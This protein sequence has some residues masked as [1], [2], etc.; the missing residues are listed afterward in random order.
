MLVLTTLFISISD[1]LPKTSYVKA[2]D[3]WLIINLLVP[4]FE[5]ILQTLI[6]TW[7]EDAVDRAFT[8][9]I[10]S[11]NT[12]ADDNRRKSD[13]LLYIT[14]LVARAALPAFYIL[15]CI[16]FF[17]VQISKQNTEPLT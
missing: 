8:T 13:R 15:F 9:T 6:N 10:I 7:H 11:N 2:M 1:K 3:I 12:K 5:I 4:F 17:G 14:K 16:C